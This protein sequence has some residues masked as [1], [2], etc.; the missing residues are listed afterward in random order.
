MQV[1][2]L[3]MMPHFSCRHTEQGQHLIIR[4]RFSSRSL[5]PAAAIIRSRCAVLP[6]QAHSVVFHSVMIVPVLIRRRS[7][8]LAAE[9]EKS[10]SKKKLQIFQ[11]PQEDFP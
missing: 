5:H 11:A 7:K 9:Q 6:A 1:L 8:D 3:N 10:I 2:S 4:L